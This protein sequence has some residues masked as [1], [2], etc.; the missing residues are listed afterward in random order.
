MMAALIVCAGLM[1]AAGVALAA[2]AAHTAPG[3]GL[4][5]AAYLLL[6][7]AAALLGVSANAPQA[8]GPGAAAVVGAGFVIGCLLFSGD[9]AL[10]VLAGHRLFPMAAPTGGVILIGSWLVLAALAVVA[11]RGR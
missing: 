2:A 3:Q 10:R 6:I 5:A 11:W 8:L 4:D 9:V 1:G 7:H